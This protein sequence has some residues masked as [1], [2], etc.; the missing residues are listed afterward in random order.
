MEKEAALVYVDKMPDIK[1]SFEATDAK[2]I[3]SASRN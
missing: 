3:E 1:P 2:L